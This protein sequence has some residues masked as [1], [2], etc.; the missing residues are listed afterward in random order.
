MRGGRV[1]FSGAVFFLGGDTVERV[2]R[3]FRPALFYVLNMNR[4]VY[5]QYDVV[6]IVSLC[7]SVKWC[8]CS[9]WNPPC[10]RCPASIQAQAFLALSLVFNNLNT[11][12]PTSPSPHPWCAL[13]M[14]GPSCNRHVE[15]RW[16]WRRC[17]TASCSQRRRMSAPPQSILSPLE[18][19]LAAAPEAQNLVLSPT[20][21]APAALVLLRSPVAKLSAR[22]RPRKRRRPRRAL[23][24]GAVPR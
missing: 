3:P 2:R 23:V 21:A 18:G 11:T 9:S 19:A 17:H 14:N 1:D 16:F 20:P 6:G 10:P 24:F 5:I 15:H 22:S 12:V 7:V 13:D 8:F 4:L